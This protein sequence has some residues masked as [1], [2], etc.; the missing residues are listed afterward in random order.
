MS[1]RIVASIAIESPLPQL[2]RL[3]DYEVAQELAGEI[4]VGQRVS[5][6]FGNSKTKLAG[7][8]VNLSANSDFAGKLTRL[9]E[10]LSPASVLSESVYRTCRAVADRQATA[11][12][13]V[14][15]MAV[16]KR[17]VA[18][19]KKW[20]AEQTEAKSAK[21]AVAASPVVKAEAIKT[22]AIVRPVTDSVSSWARHVATK[23]IEA[24]QLGQSVIVCL[25]D[26]RDLAALNDWLANQSIDVVLFD[27][28]TKAS[29]QYSAFLS[30]LDARPRVILGNRSALLAPAHNLGLII[31]WDDGDSSH[32]QQ[33]SPYI[34]SRELAMIR[35]SVEQCSLHIAAHSRTAEVQRLIDIDYLVDQT[36]AFP[37]P[38][39]AFTESTQRLDSTAWQAIRE[40]AK[41]GPVLVQVA[42][43]GFSTALYCSA[44]SKRANCRTCAGPI[45]V[46]DHNQNACRWCN[47]IST[48]ITCGD[49]GG[50]KFKQG[51]AGA[52]RTV[53]ELG[54]MFPGV[55]ILESTAEQRL[56]RVNSK[57]QVVVATPGAEPYADG[58][59]LAAVILDCDAQLTK[60]SLRATEDAIRT[61]SNAIAMLAPNG[62][63]VLVGLAGNLG[64]QLALWNH[65]QLAI[66][67]LASRRE[68]QFPPACRVVSIESDSD[69]IA[70]VSE[71]L[72]QFVGA[73]V[74]GPTSDSSGLQRLLVKFPYSIGSA[75]A[76]HL[77]ALAL[78]NNIGGSRTNAKS[79]RQQRALRIKMDDPE[80]I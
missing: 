60:D 13:D 10:V 61:W 31:L 14:I 51:R 23:A 59:Y 27:N 65:Q 43:R 19:E 70:S 33:Q 78:A 24:W 80:V 63:A 9:T 44:C 74:F 67:E 46:N 22:T 26:Y 49:C 8:V 4:K 73:E 20:L 58:G 38:K 3:F 75:L 72:S 1:N 37:I 32:M 30:C 28:D 21:T 6:P 42:R 7:Y 45:W 39:V 52:A 54:R 17:S 41:V 68:I 34:H 53:A 71:S 55:K 36:I 35:Q 50:R 15:R 77:K 56:T 18:V 47:R 48:D 2:D 5:V 12:G 64:Q 16:P 79:G 25:P 11:I 66:D 62:R 76:S 69:R 29:V 57:P 40:A